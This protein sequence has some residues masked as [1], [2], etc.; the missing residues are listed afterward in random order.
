M[1]IC[2]FGR[3]P[4]CVIWRLSRLL[5]RLGWLLIHMTA[6]CFLWVPMGGCDG[7]VAHSRGRA[8]R[9]GWEMLRE[10][11][12]EEAGIAQRTR[13]LRWRLLSVQKSESAPRVGLKSSSAPASKFAGS[14]R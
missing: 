5:K 4:G 3:A 2:R 6:L 8:W 9:D 1:R 7:D 11:H 14:F 10:K 13:R 12:V